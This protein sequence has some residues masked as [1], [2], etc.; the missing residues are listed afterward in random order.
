MRRSASADEDCLDEEVFGVVSTVVFNQAKTK[1]KAFLSTVCYFLLN[2]LL[3]S[4]F[5]LS[6]HHG[7]YLSPAAPLAE[8]CALVAE[9]WPG[10]YVDAEPLPLASE[11][12]LIGEYCRQGKGRE[13]KGREGERRFGL[14]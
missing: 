9:A 8:V 1:R 13:G 2:L 12:W 10:L 4:P 14:V 3:A 11:L 7:E 5:L 6:S